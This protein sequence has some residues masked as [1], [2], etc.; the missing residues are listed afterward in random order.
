[1]ESNQVSF[2]LY[3]PVDE[4]QNDLYSSIPLQLHHLRNLHLLG[5]CSERILENA[6]LKKACYL[7][8]IR[9]LGMDRKN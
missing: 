4:L 8:L 7:Q 3:N 2:H 1:M 9:N 6:L 5:F